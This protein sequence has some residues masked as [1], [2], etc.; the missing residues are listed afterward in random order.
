MSDQVAAYRLATSGAIGANALDYTT[1]GL[2]AAGFMLQ[3]YPE[4]LRSRYQLADLPESATALLEA[5][6]PSPR[7]PGRPAG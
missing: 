1:V 2:F 7:V 3:R 5:D 6:R 4:L